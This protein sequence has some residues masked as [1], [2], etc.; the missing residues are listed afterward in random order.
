MSITTALNWRYATKRMNGVKIPKDK[1][2]I[3]LDAISLAPSS[4]GLQPY[5]ILIIENKAMLEKIKPIAMMQPQITEASALLVFA[6]WDKITQEKIDSYIN[7]MA[8]E[9]NVTVDSLTQMKSYIEAQLKNSDNDNFNWNS[10]QAYIALGVALVAAAELEI[11]S[12]PMEGFDATKLDDLLE[13]KKIGLKSSVLMTLGYRD[14]KND[15]LANL[16]KIRRDKEKLFVKF[17]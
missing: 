10:K 11:D 4:F 12:T 1:L 17:Q 13:L 15:Y 16:K 3:L 8:K 14:V 6:V 7:Q 9:R 2:D 5:S